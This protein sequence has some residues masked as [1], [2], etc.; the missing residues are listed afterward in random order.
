M[1]KNIEHVQWIPSLYSFF[2]LDINKQDGVS[3]IMNR[4]SYIKT[5]LESKLMTCMR[6]FVCYAEAG[7]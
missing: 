3:L 1:I 5:M 7:L 2:S 4:K 6:Y